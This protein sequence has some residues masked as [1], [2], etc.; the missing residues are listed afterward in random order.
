MTEAPTALLANAVLRRRLVTA[1]CLLSV[2]MVAIEVTIVSTAMPTIVAQLDRFQIFSWVFAAYILTSAVTAP[3]YGR[4]ADLYGRKRVY[5]VGAT[6]FLIGSALCG[7]A[8]SMVLL[9]AFR[10]IQGAGAGALQPLTITILGDVY[11]A[12][13]RA[14]V[15][16]WQSGVWGLAAI[17]GPVLGA[18]IVEHMPWALVFWINI[19][20]GILTLAMLALF[21]DESPVR[22]EHRVDYLGSILLMLGVGAVLMAIVQADDLPG[23][24]IGA[25]AAGGTAALALLVV[26][27]RRAREPI[28]PFALWRARSVTASNLGGLCI[29]GVL[30]CTTVF[31]PTYVQGVLGRSATVAGMTLAAQTIAWT[32][33]SVTAARVMAYTSFARAGAAGGAVLIVGCAILVLADRSSG[34]SWV[35]SGATI[36]GLGM[37]LCNTTFLVA[38]QSEVGWGDRG[39]AVSSNIFLRSIGMSLGA[40]LGGALVNF[41]IARHAPG[42]GDAVRQILTPE[43]RAGLDMQVLTQVSEA[44]AQGL[45]QVYVVAGALAAGALISALCLPA[46][47][48][49]HSTPKR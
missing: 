11:S 34:L 27:E 19:P 2:F 4:L 7:F 38:C 3:V 18:F 33:G 42:A 24:L 47:L 17:I 13:E 8:N 29:G 12:Q 14:R 44:I 41:S 9:I 45:N 39:G 40:A 31:L 21:F 46:G 16:A 23:W 10:T 25:L 22:R 43:T 28:V 30:M 6:L 15:Q 20:V 32:V 5:Y 48:S 1:A 37:G 35:A 36:V 49:L 26:H